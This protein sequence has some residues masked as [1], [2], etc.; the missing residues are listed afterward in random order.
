MMANLSLFVVRKIWWR[1]GVLPLHGRAHRLQ[2][3]EPLQGLL[4]P[5]DPIFD[6]LQT[7]IN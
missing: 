1:R 6:L 3:H 4:V 2:R 5:M 7:A